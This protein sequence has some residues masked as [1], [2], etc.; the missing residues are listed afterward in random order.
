MR[1]LGIDIGGTN[2]RAGLVE[3]NELVRVESTL[4]RKDREH[5]CANKCD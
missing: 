5:Q 3:E 1:L 2:M 4:V